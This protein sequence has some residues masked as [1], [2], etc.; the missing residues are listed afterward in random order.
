M[1][2]MVPLALVLGL[3]AYLGRRTEGVWVSPGPL[4]AALWSVYLL[5]AALVFPALDQ[6]PTAILYTFA[7]GLVMCA[8]S[9]VALRAPVAEAA[10]D[11]RALRRALPGLEVMAALTLV[12][13]VVDLQ[14]LFHRFGY[15]LS[16]VLS[17]QAVVAV[18]IGARSQA[19]AKA[20]EMGLAEWVCYLVL[21][22]GA[23]AGGLLFRLAADRK[24]RVFAVVALVAGPLVLGLYGSRMGALF[25]G[26]FWVAAYLAAA[27]ATAPSLRTLDRRAMTGGAVAALIG[28]L[29]LSVLVQVVRYASNFAAVGWRNVL[30]DAFGFG[31]ALG[32]WMDERGV[33]GS[34]LAAGARS[35][36]KLV[37]PFGIS[38]PPIAAIPVSFTSSNIFTLL[39]DLIEDFGTAG[40]LVVLALLGWLGRRAFERARQGGLWH[41]PILFG[42]Y[43]FVFTSFAV[44]IFFYTATLA[45]FVLAVGYLGWAAWRAGPARAPEVVADP[46]V[47]EAIP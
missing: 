46:V 20:S 7:A 36:T 35:L 3:V 18:T 37:A 26:A 25:G 43:V 10:R 44:G 6:L 13:A 27:V 31:G 34:G 5:V 4:F 38:E 15:S 14:I 2:A 47:P 40:S 9:V 16:E 1:T 28:I 33:V 8:G 11:A 45:A 22:T 19:Y 41:L 29:G 24:D 39:R 17:Y 42:I 30:A 23:I 21:Y 32:I 12:A